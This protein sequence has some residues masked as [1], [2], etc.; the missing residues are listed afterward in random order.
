MIWEILI[1]VAIVGVIVLLGRRLPDL[2]EDGGSVF[3]SRVWEESNRFSKNIFQVPINKVKL[4]TRVKKEEEH[5]ESIVTE[6][7]DLLVAEQLFDAK[8]YQKAEKFYLRALK[9][10][11]QNDKIYGRLGIIYLMK[12]HFRHSRDAFEAAVK[13]DPTVASRYF[14]LGLVYEKMKN[15]KKAAENF[16]RAFDLEPASEKYY[17]AVEKYK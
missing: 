3:W 10:E 9:Q 8:D 1:I 14:N 13:I 16:R 15:P 11:S 5:E 7:N 12:K 2:N 4:L 17:R 6:Q